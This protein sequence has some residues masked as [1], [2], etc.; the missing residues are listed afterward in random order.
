MNALRKIVR[1]IL[2]KLVYRVIYKVFTIKKVKL[3]KYVFIDKVGKKGDS[4]P[5]DFIGFYEN[6]KNHP[7]K[8]ISFLYLDKGKKSF[9]LNIIA[10]L[11]NI[12]DAKLVFVNDAIGALNSINKRK[13]TKVVQLWHACGAF[14]KFGYATV[15][16]L[17]GSD[18]KTAELYPMYKVEDLFCVSSDDVIE[19]YVEATHLPK[20]RI[21]PLGTSRTDVFFDEEYL[22]NSKNKIKNIFK[23]Q[24]KIVLYAP[25]F[26]GKVNE[27]VDVFLLDVKNLTESICG[28]YNLIIKLH[29][30]ATKTT[31]E[32]ANEYSENKSVFVV[33]S[34]YDINELLIGSDV[35]ITDYSSVV[36]E[37]SFM[38]RPMIF[39]SP[40]IDEYYNER[41][42]FYE[43][44]SF[45]PGPIVKTNDELI[46]AIK[47]IENWFDEKRIKDFKQKYLSACDG[48]STDK[49]IK[50]IEN[51]LL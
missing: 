23:E 5:S 14:K 45:V 46:K 31:K 9:I 32:I 30:F 8:E 27:P 16:L 51:N 20:E 21:K 33:E 12:C 1:F 44:N 3:N 10:M 17:G 41:G 48:H 6:Y 37:Y 40:D 42:F 25:T 29:P 13:G 26:R 7:S 39:F 35:L 34:E 4:I 28:E 43:Y 18:E 47:G 19:K 50:Y 36:F 11:Y 38:N 24:K 49:I 2:M 22:S 15:G